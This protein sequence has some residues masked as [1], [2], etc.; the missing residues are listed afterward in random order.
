MKPSK[1][2]STNPDEV[3]I[4]TEQGR[5]TGAVWRKEVG[6]QAVVYGEYPNIWAHHKLITTKAKDAQLWVEANRLPLL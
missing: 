6:Y 2:W 5:L 1:S 4:L 3:L